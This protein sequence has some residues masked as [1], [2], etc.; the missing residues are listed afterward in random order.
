VRIAAVADL[1]ARADDAERL[2]KTF[3]GVDDEADVLVL[4]GDLTDHGRPEEAEA[5]L[6]ALDGVE[7]PIVAVFGNHDHEFGAL[8]DVVR[9]LE[10]RGVKLVDRASAVVDGVGFAGAKGFAGGFAERVVRAFGETPLKAFVAESVIEADALRNA[11]RALGTRKRVAVL[12]YAPVQATLDGEPLEIV[13]FLGTSR[14]GAAIDEA[15]C[16]LALHGHAHGGAFS[17]ATPGG[18]PV[19]NV[20]KPVLERSGLERGYAVFTV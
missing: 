5:L 8:D 13:P 9:M 3:E 20:S 6:A 4:P 16:E 10:G 7:I 14:L 11:L 18:V 1:H 12:H 2:A 19:Y 17:G 15:G